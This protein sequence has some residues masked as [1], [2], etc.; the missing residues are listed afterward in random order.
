[1]GGCIGQTNAPVGATLGEADA[2]VAGL[3]SGPD[4]IGAVAHT[5]TATTTTAT[6]TATTTHGSRRFTRPSVSGP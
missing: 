1:M 6:T 3:G 2:D 4:R 5:P